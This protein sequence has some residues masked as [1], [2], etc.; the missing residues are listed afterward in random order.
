MQ[1]I[2][3]A[4]VAIRRWLHSPIPSIT[5]RYRLQVF[6]TRSQAMTAARSNA[7]VALLR[8][9]G[10]DKWCFLTCP[11]GCSQQMALNLM[12]T[13]HPAWRV[14]RTPHGPS[15]F[16]SVDST[17]CGAHFVIREGRIIWC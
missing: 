4:Y 16:P 17:T 9:G 5:P 1:W 13:H 14:V 8:S 6:E 7:I 15:I 3:R 2:T 11:C 12:K 10:A